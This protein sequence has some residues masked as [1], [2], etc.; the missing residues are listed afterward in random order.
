MNKNK[1]KKQLFEIILSLF[2]W[3]AFILAILTAVL[4]ILSA[5]SSEQNGKEIFNRKF[6]IVASNSMSKTI[7]SENEKIHF[8]AGDIIIIKTDVNTY[9]L[10]EGDVISFFSYNKDSYSKT[11]THKIRSVKKSVNGSLIGYETYGINTGVSD[12]VLVEPEAV[13]GQYVG[14]IIGLGNVFSFLKTP[15]G[16]YLSVLTPLILLIVFFSISIGRYL[17]ERKI[18]I[19]MNSQSIKKNAIGVEK[20]AHGIEQNAIGVELNSHGV[21]HNASEIKDIKERISVLEKKLQDA[22]SKENKI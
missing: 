17:G 18:T 20:N 12:G 16:Y 2:A 10:K 21:E 19:E 9:S 5:F 11:L 6:L 1:S 7:E 13:I 14:K 4:S 22:I 8:N 15:Q 3:L